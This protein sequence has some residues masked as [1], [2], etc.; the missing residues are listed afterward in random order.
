MLYLNGLFLFK[1]FDYGSWNVSSNQFFL[2][3]VE[4]LSCDPADQSY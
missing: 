1:K 2:K 4:W 3:G